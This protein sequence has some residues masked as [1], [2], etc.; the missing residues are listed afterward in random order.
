MLGMYRCS[1]EKQVDRGKHCVGWVKVYRRGCLG[2]LFITYT[3]K[4]RQVVCSFL[5]TGRGSWVD[6]A[7]AENVIVQAVNE[8]AD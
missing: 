5:W 3:G 7:T 4:G 2:H 8:V 1:I 6:R